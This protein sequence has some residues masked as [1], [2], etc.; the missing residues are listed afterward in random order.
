[1]SGDV[2]FWPVLRGKPDPEARPLS[3][4]RL[5]CVARRQRWKERP[6]PV[7]RTPVSGYV[8]FWPVFDVGG[9]LSSRRR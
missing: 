4:M 3:W 9:G 2:R 1:M 6:K 7:H 8:R 5:L